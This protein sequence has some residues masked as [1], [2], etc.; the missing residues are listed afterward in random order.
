MFVGCNEDTVGND[1]TGSISGTVTS[2]SSGEPIENVEISTSPASTTVLTDENGMFI[3]EN[4]IIDQYSV[5]AESEDYV[6]K[7]ESVTV[8]ADIT[9]NVIF[10]LVI[11]SANNRQP[12][13]PVAIT[14]LDNAEVT[15][16]NVDFAWNSTDPDGDELTYELKIRNDR[17]EEVLEF[18]NIQDTTYNVS[19]LKYGYKYFW[20]VAVS[21][22]INEPVLSQVY[23]FK[24][25][26][27]P[28]NSYYFVREIDNNNVIFSS[29]EKGVEVRLTDLNKNSFRPRKNNSINRIAFLRIVGS[30]T[31]LFTMKP[32]GSDVFQVT[33]NIPVKSINNERVGYSWSNDGSFLLYPNLDKLYKISATGEGKEIIYDAPIGRFIINTTVSA[34]N[35]VIVLHTTDVNGYNAEIFTIDFNGNR[36]KTIVSNVMGSLGGLDID[37]TNSL[38]LY[39]RDVSGFESD[40]DRELNTKMFIYN[41]QNDTEVSLS[42]GKENGTNDTDPRFSPDEA[43]VIFVNASNAP[44]SIKNIYTLRFDE[45]LNP[46]EIDRILLIENGKMPDWE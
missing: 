28:N 5:K 8:T 15:D 19:D 46:L 37:V 22:S 26:E 14:P 44:M 30:T 35:S 31:Q 41:L 2:E 34:D 43:A 18:S 36:E 3:L 11:S 10:K 12:S 4:V 27:F 9:S 21:D 1:L 6:T 25:T 24:I 42:G 17:N 20:Q 33:S 23:S 29:N 38:V 16:L 45:D 7:F 40:E 13:A 32:D 39:T